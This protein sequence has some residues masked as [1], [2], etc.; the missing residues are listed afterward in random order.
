MRRQVVFIG[1]PGSGKGTQSKR[2]VKTHGFVHLST[3]DILRDEIARKTSLG[4]RVSAIISGGQLVDDITTFELVKNRINL[5]NN[6]YIF[7]G[8]PRTVNQANLLDSELSLDCKVVAFYFE[9][10]IEELVK[11]VVSRRICE[12]CGSIFNLVSNVSRLDGTC[13]DCGGILVHRKDDSEITVRRRME[14][15]ENRTRPVI[16]YYNGRGQLNRIE[17]IK[18]AD[19][20]ERQIGQVLGLNIVKN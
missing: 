18:S 2:L 8:F 17:A 5:A 6:S 4:E 13:D 15:F 10:N 7:D 11:R 3:G 9:I 12:G 19:E 16:D 20:I 14:V 1:A